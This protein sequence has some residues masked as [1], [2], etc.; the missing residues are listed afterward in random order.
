MIV[1]RS[2]P[3]HRQHSETQPL[4]LN[5]KFLTVKMPSATKSITVEPLTVP[6][7]SQVNCGAVVSNVDIENL[8]SKTP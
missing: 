3:S 5:F 7:G 8:T 6:K 2:Q 1:H 4:F